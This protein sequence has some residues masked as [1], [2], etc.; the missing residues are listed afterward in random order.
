MA[1]NRLSISFHIDAPR[2]Q[3]WGKIADWNSQGEWMLQTKVWVTSDI[4][5][6]E[7][8][9]IAAFTGPLHRM[10]PRFKRIGLLDLMIVTR[11][12]PP[13]LCEVEHVGAV[14]KGSGSFTLRESIHGGT[15][16]DW[17]E[18]VIAPKVIFLLLAPFLYAGVRISLA[19][20]ARSFQ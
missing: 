5:E 12:E 15:H 9:S 8:T 10:Y 16:F 3:V 19:R 4:S 13:M 20:F 6:G 17:S 7:G 14:L 11:W 18:V 1:N 2:E